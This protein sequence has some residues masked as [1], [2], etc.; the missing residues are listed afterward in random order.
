MAH[1]PPLVHAGKLAEAQACVAA[2]P[3]SPLQATMHWSDDEERSQAGVAAG[4]PEVLAS[5]Q[6]PHRCF[7][8]SQTGPD[9]ELAQSALV[10]QHPSCGFAKWSEAKSCTTSCCDQEPPVEPVKPA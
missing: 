7:A 1:V 9:A 6:V 5:V 10:A 4:Q 2:D 8:G 3:L